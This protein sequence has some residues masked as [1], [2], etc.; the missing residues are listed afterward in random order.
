MDKPVNEHWS[1]TEIDNLAKLLIQAEKEY[2]AAKIVLE[3]GKQVIAE[4]FDELSSETNWAS[5]M[6]GNTHTIKRSTST[7]IDSDNL[8][9]AL[10]EWVEPDE[11]LSMI[12]PARTKVVDEP[13]RVMLTAV[14]KIKKQGGII[15]DKIESVSV[16]TTKSIEA[17]PKGD[18]E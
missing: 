10:G 14:N 5:E 4:K 11:L 15:A 12:R 2:L 17:K 3:E 7:H 1:K 18:V 8:R 9:S 16:K 13:E 6:V